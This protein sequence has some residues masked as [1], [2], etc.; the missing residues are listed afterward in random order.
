MSY[1]IVVF[2]AGLAGSFH[3]AGMCS[4]FACALGPDFSNKPLPNVARHLLYNFGR[5]VTYGFMGGVAAGLSSAVFTTSSVHLIP[6]IQQVLTAL[7]G[8]LMIVMALKLFGLFALHPN[9]GFGG[10]VFAGALANLTNA[11]GRSMPLALGVFNGFLPCPLVY[12]FLAQAAST[13]DIGAGILTM[14]AL[15]F[16]TFPTMLAMGWLGLRIAPRFRQTGLRVA[17]TMVLV[18]GI[19][20]L[21]RVLIPGLVPQLAL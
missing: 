7:A 12:A 13:G 8:G 19:V 5:L 20:T 9:L 14:A 2:L 16:G 10:Q 11:P 15:G 3:C 6:V 17:G 18:F 21:A 1:Y 4:G